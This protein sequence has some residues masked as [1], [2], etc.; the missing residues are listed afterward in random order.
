MS[1][2]LTDTNQ[3]DVDIHINDVMVN[4]GLAIFK[5][6]AEVDTPADTNKHLMVSQ[7]SKS[8]RLIMP[9]KCCIFL[10]SFLYFWCPVKVRKRLLTGQSSKPYF[11][12]VVFWQFVQL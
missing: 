7:H 12:S 11:A 3:S 6:D 1:L 9:K 2:C 5:P 4:D 8:L 10:K